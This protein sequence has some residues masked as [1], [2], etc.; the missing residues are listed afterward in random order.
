MASQVRSLI[1]ELRETRLLGLSLLWHCF[2]HMQ[3]FADVI[4][5]LSADWTMPGMVFAG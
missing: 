1:L 2:H 4:P 5:G 3:A